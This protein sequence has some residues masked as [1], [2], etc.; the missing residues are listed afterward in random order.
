MPESYNCCLAF[1]LMQLQSRKRISPV[2]APP[3]NG[4]LVARSSSVITEQIKC[5]QHKSPLVLSP[6]TI[7]VTAAF[8]HLDNDDISFPHWHLSGTRILIGRAEGLEIV[9]MSGHVYIYISITALIFGS[10][11]K[12]VTI[13]ERE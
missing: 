12:W 4:S 3:Q 10:S 6:H 2:E 1:K 11:G 8:N 13:S 7:A 9:L 5:E